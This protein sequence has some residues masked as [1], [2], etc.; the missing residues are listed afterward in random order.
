[1]GERLEAHVLDNGLGVLAAEATDIVLCSADPATYAE[2]NATYL[3]GRKIFGAGACFGAPED[4]APN[5]RKA[6]S[7]AIAG[8]AVAVSGRATHWAAIDTANARLLVVG[9]LIASAD[10]L[11]GGT[12]SLDPVA[13]RIPA[14]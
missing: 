5:G 1:M 7:P 11:S 2:A 8:G 3:L 4:A 13:A 9:R 14:G 12:F 6:V 10:V